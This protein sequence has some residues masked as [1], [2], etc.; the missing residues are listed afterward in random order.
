MRTSSANIRA[1]VKQIKVET[2][3]DGPDIRIFNNREASSPSITNSQKTPTLYKRPRGE[4]PSITNITEENPDDP[5]KI[6]AL[7][8]QYKR[9]QFK[10]RRNVLTIMDSILDEGN[11]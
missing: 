8:N 9:A 5:A 2:S 3:G 6:V 7:K 4:F 10:K 11:T 1:L